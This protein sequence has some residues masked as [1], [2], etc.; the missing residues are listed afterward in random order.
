MEICQA[1]APKGPA[2]PVHLDF[3]NLAPHQSCCPW[4]NGTKQVTSEVAEVHRRLSSDSGLLSIRANTLV[5]RALEVEAIAKEVQR[6]KRPHGFNE[7][8]WA[9]M[10]A[11][12]VKKAVQARNDATEASL[13]VRSV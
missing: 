3:S 11:N 5:S 10:V 8:K 9:Q 4:C 1:C 2:W 7:F 12:A 6:K 13:L